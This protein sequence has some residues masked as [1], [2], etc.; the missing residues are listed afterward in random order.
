VLEN[1]EQTPVNKWIKTEY[2]APDLLKEIYGLIVN[3]IEE[4]IEEVIE[5]SEERE[6]A[7]KQIESNLFA[8][9]GYISDFIFSKVHNT[10]FIPKDIDIFLNNEWLSKILLNIVKQV[11]TEL[12]DAVNFNVEEEYNIFLIVNGKTKAKMLI[13]LLL[14][15]KYSVLPIKE[16]PLNS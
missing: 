12:P 3:S 11:Q 15:I 16:L 4:L 7:K 10:P 6:I 14:L 13:I 8:A 5:P 9:G 1:L 2:N